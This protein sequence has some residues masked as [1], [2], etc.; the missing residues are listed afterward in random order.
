MEL[1]WSLCHNVYARSPTSSGRGR[2]ETQIRGRSG[3]PLRRTGSPGRLQK[4]HLPASL[5]VQAP[6][7]A[8]RVRSRRA[9]AGWSPALD[10]AGG[11]R[12]TDLPMRARARTAP[13]V[14]VH[15]APCDGTRAETNRCGEGPSG[16]K[17]VEG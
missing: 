11:A 5:S 9:L 13:M 15:P 16:N 1:R 17:S 10:S 3:C 7:A 14:D 6:P 12:Q 4:G 8:S 2:I